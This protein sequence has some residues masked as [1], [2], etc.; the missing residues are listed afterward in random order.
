MRINALASARCQHYL[1]DMGVSLQV[2]VRAM[3]TPHDRLSTS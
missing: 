1:G 2:W 3:E